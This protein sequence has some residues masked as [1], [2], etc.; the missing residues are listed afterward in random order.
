MSGPG[1]IPLSGFPPP[2]LYLVARARE[3]E[4]SARVRLKSNNQSKLREPQ[5]ARSLLLI[6]SLRNAGPVAHLNITSPLTVAPANERASQSRLRARQNTREKKKKK[7][8][9]ARALHYF[10]SIF[11]FLFRTYLVTNCV[12]NSERERE[13]YRY[14]RYA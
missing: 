13:S 4:H 3:R 5:R 12:R 10:Q 9:R 7:K 8:K 6:I 1:G 11:C 2:S 14:I